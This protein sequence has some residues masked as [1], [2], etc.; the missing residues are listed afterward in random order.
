MQNKKGV[1]YL[2]PNTL[3]NPQTGLTI[4]DGVARTVRNTGVFIVENTRNARRYLK[5]LDP[6]LEI[7]PLIFHEL[8]KHTPPGDIPGF[9]E[10]CMHG[11]DTAL[12]SEAGAPGVA[13][14]GAAVVSHAHQNGIRVV[15]LTGPSSIL[16][17][18]MASGLNGQSF[19][20]HGYLPVNR[21]ERTRAIR[22]LELVAQRS[23]ETQI[24]IETPYRND[25][26]L[27]DI[28]R[29]CSPA[30]RLC[31]AADITLDSEWIRT[32]PVGEWK[33]EKPDLHKRP[34]VFL[35]GL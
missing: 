23:G 20:F 16:M 35:V 21:G 5:L 34:A 22:E 1:L 31:V 26:L 3:G 11:Q 18:L 25:G 28:I 29:S 10:E 27:A 14:P 2:L 8:N 19:R 12:V 6:G 13:D 24:F 33:K 17:S 7:D 4:P 15:P 9:L 32:M 30:T